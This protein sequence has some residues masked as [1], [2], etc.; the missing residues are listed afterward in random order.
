MPFIS[1]RKSD[2]KR[3]DPETLRPVRSAVPSSGRNI[4]PARRRKKKV[5]YKATKSFKM[6]YNKLLPSKERR[7]NWTDTSL[8]TAT[9]AAANTVKVINDYAKGTQSDERIRS[10]VHSSYVQLR[11]SIVSDSTT[12]YKMMRLMCVQDR[13]GVGTVLN[14]TTFADLFQDE[15]Y[16]DAAMDTTQKMARYNINR[17]KYKVFFSKVLQLPPEIYGNYRIYENFK[18]NAVDW[19]LPSDDA[20][21]I[22]TSGR[23]YLIAILFHADNSVGDAI[24]VTFSCQARVFFKDYNRNIK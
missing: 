13:N 19:F 9:L 22:P 11:G 4:V 7:Y 5:N 20:A 12:R 3:G 15:S 8:T 24:N 18:V 17:N 1:Y 2:W 10:A 23:R 14:T 6:A 16:A 21:T